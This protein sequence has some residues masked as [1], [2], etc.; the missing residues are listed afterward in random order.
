MYVSNYVG[1]LL[2]LFVLCYDRDFFFCL[3]VC[4]FVRVYLGLVRLVFVRLR[5]RWFDLWCG[6]A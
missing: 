6:F 5:F 2:C 4:W 3:V 1:L